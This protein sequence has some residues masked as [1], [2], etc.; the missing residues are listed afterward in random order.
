MQKIIIVQALLDNT[1]KWQ[2]CGI[3]EVN[4]LLS[5]GWK[6]I[7][8]NPMGATSLGYGYGGAST[9]PGHNDRQLCASLMVLEKNT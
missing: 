1:G 6:V 3:E 2:E 7:S 4:D 5:N 9:R 8:S